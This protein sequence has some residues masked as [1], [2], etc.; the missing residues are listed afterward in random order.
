[1]VAGAPVL[2]STILSFNIF[3]AGDVDCCHNTMLQISHPIPHVTTKSNESRSSAPKRTP[4]SQGITEP[5]PELPKLLLPVGG[6]GGGGV[7]NGS[8]IEV[9]L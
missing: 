9:S 3:F 5:E 1:M 7:E 4:L 6:G 2:T 8:D